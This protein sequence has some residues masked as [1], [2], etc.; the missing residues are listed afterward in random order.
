MILASI[1]D[2]VKELMAVADATQ[3]KRFEMIL[4]MLEKGY[5][6]ALLPPMAVT[7]MQLGRETTISEK[8]QTQIGGTLKLQ[9]LSLGVNRGSDFAQ[10]ITESVAMLFST[11]GKEFVLPPMATPEERQAFA[12]QLRKDLFQ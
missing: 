6:P 3:M 1:P 8:T 5:D 12:A 2:T 10:G 11:N 4:E 9:I 7:H